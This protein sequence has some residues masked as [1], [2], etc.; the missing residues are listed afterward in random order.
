[1]RRPHRH[2]EI[3]SMSVLDLFAS[4]LGAFILIAIILFPY[5]K[6]DVT[7]EL[8]ASKV[9]L[10]DKQEE[11]KR[12]ERKL[13]DVTE[14]VKRQAPM[15]VRAKALQED[16]NQCRRGSAECQVQAKK[17][18]VM[19]QA[20]WKTSDDVN[21]QVTDPAGNVFSWAKANR[22]GRDYPGSK[23]MLSTDVAIGEGIEVWIE[24]EAVKGSYKVEYALSRA[25]AA[26]VPVKG[27]V[28]DKTGRKDLPELVIQPGR[29]S[30]VAASV[31]L[32]D[33][34]VVTIRQG[35]SR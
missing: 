31:D 10:L 20:E 21:L 15:V 24:P 3:F 32:N 9:L 29:T 33:D 34:G 22:T 26:P 23:A 1:M 25:S 8:K 27:I 28:F 4:A 19:V 2:I 16:L 12:E 11:K 30:V 13:G 7:E 35:A 6:K 17:N 14:R 18:F 5:Y